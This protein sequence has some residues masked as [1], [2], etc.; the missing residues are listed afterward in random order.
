MKP[1]PRYWIGAAAVWAVTLSGAGLT[2]QSDEVLITLKDHRFIP[3]TI[4]V[5]A[6]TRIKITIK[7]LDDSDEEFDSYSLNREK[8]IRGN[9]E[10]TIFVGPLEPG[11]YPFEGEKNSAT[12]KGRLIVKE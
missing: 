4:E 11:E 5:P 12:A 2:A 3:D 10:E 8:L 6:Q 9:S 7:N 1:F